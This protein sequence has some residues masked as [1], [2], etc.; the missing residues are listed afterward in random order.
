MKAKYGDQIDTLYQKMHEMPYRNDMSETEYRAWWDATE[1]IE[2]QIKDLKAQNRLEEQSE[3]RGQTVFDGAMRLNTVESA[4]TY[5]EAGYSVIPLLGKQAAINWTKYQTTRAA[6]SQVHNWQEKNVLQNIGLVCG[7]VSGNLVVMDC[8]GQNAIN[9][10]EEAFPRL[11]ETYYVETG[12]GVGRHYYFRTHDYTHTTRA[13]KIPGVGNLEL[14][15]GGC[16]V[17]APPSVHPDTHARYTV[18]MSSLE[19]VRQI[20]RLDDVEHW[21][22]D[23]IE[24]KRRAVNNGHAKIDA[25]PK[26]NWHPI[27]PALID[28]IAGVLLGKGYGV[29]HT[30]V[31][32]ECLFPER[33]ANKDEH[34]S[35]GFDT[36]TGRCHCF[37]C[38]FLKTID[39]TR[40]LNIDVNAYG[41]LWAK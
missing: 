40:R 22:F 25:S 36:R 32:G 35:F 31:F 17:V 2:T 8:D 13:C 29:K 41:G 9:E 5:L 21:I 1:A 30:W 37:T 20:D 27:N 33:H 19:D 38:G 34:P 3:G 14:R 4:L 11:C 7:R 6:A 10:F 15:S 28:A 39:V 26:P 12:S 16:Y 24:A 18:G 23:F